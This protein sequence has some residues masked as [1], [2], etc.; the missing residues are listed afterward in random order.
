MKAGFLFRRVIS[1]FR[2]L[3]PSISY[4]EA[5]H[6]L[7]WY[8]RVHQLKQCSQCW[9]VTVMS[10]VETS[11]YRI[12][13]IDWSRLKVGAAAMDANC[14]QATSPIDAGRTRTVTLF[15]SM[16]RDVCRHGGRP[17][18]TKSWWENPSAQ[19]V[20]VVIIPAVRHLQY[21]RPWRL[22][23]VI[24]LINSSSTRVAGGYPICALRG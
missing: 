3:A 13:D 11:A 10:M 19:P 1:H 14:Y 9:S 7:T 21:G 17:G 15:R 5:I 22:T 4:V 8:T 2:C 6:S 16:E 12:G 18:G 20:P 24:A 23:L